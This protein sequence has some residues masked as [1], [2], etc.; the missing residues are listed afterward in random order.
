MTTMSTVNIISNHPFSEWATAKSKSIV[1]HATMR[2]VAACDG[3]LRQRRLIWVGAAHRLAV[4]ALLSPLTYA[5][6]SLGCEPSC[7]AQALDDQSRQTQSLQAMIA[8]LLQEGLLEIAPRTKERQISLSLLMTLV[9]EGGMFDAACKIGDLGKPIGGWTGLA[10]YQSLLPE[11]VLECSMQGIRYQSLPIIVVYLYGIKLLEPFQM[12]EQ[13]FDE[14]ALHLPPKRDAIGEFALPIHKRLVAKGNAPDKRCEAEQIARPRFNV[15]IGKVP[16]S[17][18]QRHEVERLVLKSTFEKQ[19]LIAS[20]FL[21]D[22]I[23]LVVKHERQD[24]VL[25]VPAQIAGLIYEDGKLTHG[26][27]LQ[28]QESRGD[29]PA[30]DGSPCME[31]HHF[32]T[33]RRFGNSIIPKY[34]HMFSIIDTN[35]CSPR[36]KAA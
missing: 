10:I 26:E 1:A 9:F 3:D 13:E 6:S 31:T 7:L 28:K 35:I 8:Q 27:S 33:T 5:A 15:L 16:I 22:V 4:V 29:P 12:L 17:V 36:R 32:Y 23:R 11:R 25:G 30:L 18:R 21:R 14:V 24:V 34:E 20:D 2:L 19:P